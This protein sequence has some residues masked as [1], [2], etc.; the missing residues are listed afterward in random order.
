M[1]AQTFRLMDPDTRRMMA[2]RPDITPQ[3]ARIAAT[4]LPDMP[5]PLRLS[6][7]GPCVLM[8]SNRGEGIGRYRRQAWN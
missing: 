7:A 3:I 8:A 1:A 4:R 2:L 5:R 6:Y